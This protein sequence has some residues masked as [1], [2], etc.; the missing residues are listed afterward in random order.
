[1]GQ[2]VPL[3]P[4]LSF[5]SAS[6][7]TLDTQGVSPT[8]HYPQKSAQLTV[9]IED[10]Y[11]ASKDVRPELA[12][13]FTLLKEASEHI[14]SALKFLD[15]DDLISSDDCIMKSHAVLP[16][17]FCCR[18]IG[19]GFASMISSLFHSIA[20]MN[21]AGLNRDQICVIRKCF[22]RLKSEP[23]LSF[24]DSIEL[25]TE[26]EDKDLIVEPDYFE[27]ISENLDE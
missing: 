21:G 12:T 2:I 24:E 13:A 6:T 5:G 3:R 4:D 14:D 10:I 15:E 16:E 8:V 27:G 7:A 25:V 19:D 9:D 20:N 23:F 17:L 1:M 22:N 18:S 11:P 26:L